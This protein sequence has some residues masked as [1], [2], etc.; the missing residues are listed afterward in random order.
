MEEIGDE[1]HR[2]LWE[3]YELG[4]FSKVIRLC[5]MAIHKRKQISFHKFMKAKCLNK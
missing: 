1:K 4:D 2:A 3:T 5:N